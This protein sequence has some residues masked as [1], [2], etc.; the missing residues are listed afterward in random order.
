[1][2]FPKLPESKDFKDYSKFCDLF[3]EVR[4]KRASILFQMSTE[5]FTKLTEDQLSVV[6]EALQFY[7]CRS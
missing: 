7:A 6:K 5:D 4:R 3:H 1:M 2:D